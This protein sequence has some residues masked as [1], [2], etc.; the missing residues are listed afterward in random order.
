[1]ASTVTELPKVIVAQFVG[2]SSHTLCGV[3]EP[4][5]VTERSFECEE[6]CPCENPLTQEGLI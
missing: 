6:N 3:C 2:K 5:N 4:K 1:M